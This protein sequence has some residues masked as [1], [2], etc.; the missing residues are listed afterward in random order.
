MLR[1]IYMLRREGG[2]PGVFLIEN[3]LPLA[4]FFFFDT[5]Y[6]IKIKS[7]YVVFFFV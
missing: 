4:P 1:Q 7:C 6:V 5:L 3:S 2:C